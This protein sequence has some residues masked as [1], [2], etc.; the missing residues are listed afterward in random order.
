MKCDCPEDI[1]IY[2]HHDCPVLLVD[3]Y[4]QIFP[5]EH[6]YATIEVKSSISSSNISQII[7]HTKKIRELK[8]TNNRKSI[9]TFVFSYKTSY[10]VKTLISRIKNKVRDYEYLQ[11][12]PDMIV[13]LNENFSLLLTGP[14]GKSDLTGYKMES[15]ILLFFLQNLISRIEGISISKLSLFDEYGWGKD[16]PVKIFPGYNLHQN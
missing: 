5:C 8:F 6:V 2:D 13:C 14:D 11:P 15:G 12:V 10:N 16:N 7:D 4:Y 9:E 1:V 3:D